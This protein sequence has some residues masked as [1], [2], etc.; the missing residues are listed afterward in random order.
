MSYTVAWVATKML[1]DPDLSERTRNLYEGILLKFLD[2]LGGSLIEAVTRGEIANYLNSLNHLSLKT[3][4]LHQTVIHRLFGYGVEKGFLA[5]NPVSHIKR[6]KADP[7]KGE[8]HSDELVRYLTK[9]Q[10]E[11]L[12]KVSARDKRLSTLLWLLYESGAR[13]SE[14]LSLKLIDI[15]F[16]NRQFQVTGKGNKKRYCFFGERTQEVLKQ[17]TNGFREHPH[18]SLFT[19]RMAYNRYVRPL[20]YQVAYHDL[21]AVIKNYEII[22]TIR[23]HDLRHTFATERAQIVALEVL[24]ALLGHENI[25]TT[26]IYQKITSRLAR[27]SAHAAINK[28]AESW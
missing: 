3:H 4:H 20:S 18:E 27:E 22:K 2:R 21:K 23:F 15:D 16:E 9:S 19:E 10:L 13:I 8:Y 24:R 12:F 11:C 25:Q 6:R 1:S 7:E 28:L 5:N 26:L 17:Y 14:V